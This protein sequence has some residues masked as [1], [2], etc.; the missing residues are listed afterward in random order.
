[1]GDVHKVYRINTNT[2]KVEASTI[3][4]YENKL[5]KGISEAYETFRRILFI[6]ERA[7]SFG[8]DK[9]D[10][11][12]IMTEAKKYTHSPWLAEMVSGGR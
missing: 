5:R 3:T 11:E 4:D 8:I 10:I 2:G 12:E 7:E 9:E 1:M 6:C